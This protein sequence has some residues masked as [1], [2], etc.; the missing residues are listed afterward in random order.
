VISF[1]LSKIKVAFLVV[2][3][4]F[5]SRAE[6][7]KSAP[8]QGLDQKNTLPSFIMPIKF[9]DVFLFCVPPQH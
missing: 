4:G 8:H 9:A 6:I 2:R 7:D 1:S 5:A 3:R